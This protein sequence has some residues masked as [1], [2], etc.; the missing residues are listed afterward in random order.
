MQLS[1]SWWLGKL[2]RLSE[3]IEKTLT[4]IFREGLLTSL[5]LCSSVGYQ[6]VWG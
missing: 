4:K 6:Q 1:R 3:K 5:F 2:P